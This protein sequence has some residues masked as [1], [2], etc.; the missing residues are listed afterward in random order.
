MRIRAV[1]GLPSAPCRHIASDLT[2][3]LEAPAPLQTPGSFMLVQGSLSSRTPKRKQ[4]LIFR[5][6]ILFGTQ[7]QKKKN[8]V[9]CIFISFVLAV[10]SVYAL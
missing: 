1:R 10:L 2:Q 6:D 5:G 3:P 8:Q 7:N 9:G 4:S